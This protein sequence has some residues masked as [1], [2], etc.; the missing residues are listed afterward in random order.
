[1]LRRGGTA[2]IVDNDVRRSTFGRWFRSAYPFVDPD[3]VERFWSSHGWTRTPVD[4]E[5]R[6]AS[7]AGLEAVARIELD[8]PSAEGLLADVAGTTVD[9]AVNLWWRRY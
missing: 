3:A 8:P 1:V 9:Y 4:I 6:F 7:R 5:W 2:F